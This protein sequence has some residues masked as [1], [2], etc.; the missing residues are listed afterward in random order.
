MVTRSI[1]AGHDRG[2]FSAAEIPT[3]GSPA[4]AGDSPA[5]PLEQRTVTLQVRPDAQ[6]SSYVVEEILPEGWT[7]GAISGDG[8]F[9]AASRK[10]RWG[11][12]FDH[13]ERTLRYELRPASESDAVSATLAG[14]A[15]FDGWN[16]ETAG[17][18]TIRRSTGPQLHAPVLGK[19]GSLTFRMEGEAGRRYEIQVSDDLIN[20]TAES[21]VIAD[22]DG[23]L[24]F[25]QNVQHADRQRFYRARRLAE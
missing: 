23:Q 5:L 16:A 20:W 24:E 3:G 18:N 11:V 21:T 22:A 13:Q 9:D 8:E 17:M 2:A 6:V 14:Q 7:P 4:G 15:S 19:D 1:S 10:V 25:T 12:F